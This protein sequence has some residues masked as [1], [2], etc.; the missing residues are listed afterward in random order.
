M[1][2][3]LRQIFSRRPVFSDGEIDLY[4]S[5]TDVSDNECGIEDGY[6]F[7]ILHKKTRKYVG[8]VSLRLGESPALFYLGHIGYRIKPEWRGHSYAYHACRMLIPLLAKMRMDSVVI[9]TDID[10][11]ASRRTCEKLGCQLES[12]MPVPDRY[13]GIC[14]GSAAK[15]RYI[16]FGFERT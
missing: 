14:S 1:L 7:N 15:C 9:T 16:W 13:R 2:S 3:F 6:L 11:W 10:N 5:D 4:L 12:I 8:Y